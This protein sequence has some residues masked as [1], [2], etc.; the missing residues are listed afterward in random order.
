MDGLT[1][2]LEGRPLT[3]FPAGVPVPAGAG[4]ANFDEN[5]DR[6]LAGHP[7][8]RRVLMRLLPS[9]PVLYY[10][11]HFSDGTDL[12]RLDEKVADGTAADEDVRAALL[13]E[14]QSVVCPHCAAVIRAIVVDTGHPLF[15]SDRG[16]RLREHRFRQE[17]PVCG[18]HLSL[19]ILE[20][21][22]AP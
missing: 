1:L 16:R 3:Y 21:I 14:A 20:V 4:I 5:E 7:R 11:L 10:Y 8:L 12:H 22:D 2:T 18:G 9:L 6:A 17:C 19:Y 15:A 13:G